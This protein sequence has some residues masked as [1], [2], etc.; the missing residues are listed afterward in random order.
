VAVTDSTLTSEARTAKLVE[1]EALLLQANEGLQKRGTAESICQRDSLVRLTRLYQAWN[2]PDKAAEWQQKLDE[3]NKTE[4]EAE[5]AEQDETNETEKQAA[6]DIEPGKSDDPRQN[7]A[8]GSG[9]L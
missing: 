4:P 8:A 2:E 9:L 7:N 3:F 6:T 1:A 5:G